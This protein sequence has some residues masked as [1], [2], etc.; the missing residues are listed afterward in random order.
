MY[1]LTL[2]IDDGASSKVVRAIQEGGSPYFIY[3][4]DGSPGM[5][6]SVP[7]SQVFGDTATVNILLTLPNGGP[8]VNESATVTFMRTGYENEYSTGEFASDVT[9]AISLELPAPNYDTLTVTV[10]SFPSDISAGDFSLMPIS[11]SAIIRIAT[12]SNFITPIVVLPTSESITAAIPS[13]WANGSVRKTAYLEIISRYESNTAYTPVQFAIDPL[14]STDI[15]NEFIKLCLFFTN[16][17]WTAQIKNRSATRV[18]SCPQAVFNRECLLFVI[19]VEL[20]IQ[21]NELLD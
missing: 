13:Q 16:G 7:G 1:V 3:S 4:F 14:V 17:C 20:E 9:G 11:L 8:L 10:T 21:K 18:S 2:G 15:K 6:I 5:S 19:F 12:P